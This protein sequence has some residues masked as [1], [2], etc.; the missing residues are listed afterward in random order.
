LEAFVHD[1]RRLLREADQEHGITLEVVQLDEAKKGFVRL[2]RRWVVER[3]FAWAARF[4]RWARDYERLSETL[5]ALHFVV[6]A[7]LALLKASSLLSL[8]QSA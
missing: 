1:L 4:R 3:S 7:I 6:F 2:P 8:L 5:A